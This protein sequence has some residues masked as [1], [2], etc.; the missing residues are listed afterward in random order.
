MSFG[1]IPL[2]PGVPKL[3]KAPVPRLSG[4]GRENSWC[5]VLAE[6]TESGETGRAEVDWR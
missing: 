2:A 3:P 1:L 6:C 4:V 5:H